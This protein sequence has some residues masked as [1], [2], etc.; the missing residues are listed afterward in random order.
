MLRYIIPL[1][2]SWLPVFNEYLIPCLCLVVIAFVPVLI[3]S[4]FRG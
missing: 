1:I 3:F 2:E 4:F